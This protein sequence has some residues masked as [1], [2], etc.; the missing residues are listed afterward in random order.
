[1]IPDLKAHWAQGKTM[2]GTMVIA[3]RNPAIAYALAAAG[4]D[5]MVVDCEHGSFG[6]ETIEDLA[7]ACRGAGIAMIVRIPEIRREPVLKC[8]EAGVTGILAPQV[9]TVEQAAALVSYLRYAPQG[10]RGVSLTRP[11]TEFRKVN[12]REYMKEANRR[13]VLILQVESKAGLENIDALAAVPGVDAVLIGPN[14]LS[15]SLTDGANN[16]PAAVN[17]AISTIIQSVHRQGLVCGIH[18]SQLPDVLRWREHGL[19]L[20]MWSSEITLLMAE[21]QRG[22]QALREVEKQ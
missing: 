15:Q 2:L 6:Y 14:D 20:L 3:M 16:D 10:G 4:F 13:S 5:F 7:L 12:G 9:E 11:H 17:E 18:C 8:L 21:A 1:M 19:R 22:L